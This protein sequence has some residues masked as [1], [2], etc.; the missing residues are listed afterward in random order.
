MAD[1]IT[2]KNITSVDEV[3]SV[4]NTDKVFVNDNGSFKQISVSNLMKQAPSGVTEETDPTVSE[5]AKQPTKP[6]YTADEVGAQPAL[7]IS[8]KT[9]SDT[10]YTQ[11]VKRD[12]ST[13]KLLVPA[14]GGTV[15]PE[16]IK[17]AVN[18]Y[19][20][21]NPVNPTPI[22]KTLTVENEAADAKTTGEKLNEKIDKQKGV[23]FENIGFAKVYRYGRSYFNGNIPEG[24]TAVAPLGQIIQCQPGE[25]LYCNFKLS[26]Y[27]T[28]NQRVTVINYVP[29]KNFGQFQSKSICG[30]IEQQENDIYKIPEDFTDAKA[31]FF[32]VGSMGN[33]QLGYYDR[34]SAYA[35]QNISF[36]EI[37]KSYIQEEIVPYPQ[38]EGLIVDTDKNMMLYASLF[39]A[40]SHM[41][42]A[43][44]YV[45]GD[46]I[47][48]QSSTLLN[49]TTS[50]D[51]G[52]GWYDRIGIKYIQQYECHGYEG[53]RWYSTGTLKNSA[54]ADVKKIIEAGA[55]YDY[56]VLEW[57]TNDIWSGASFG[58]A[59]DVASDADNA[60]T[61]AAIRWCIENLQ[62]NFPSTRIIVIMP[63]MRKNNS[64][65][66][67]YYTLVDTILKSYGVRRVYMAYDSGIAL[68][69]MAS[70]GIHFRY[71]DT[72]NEIKQNMIG[73]EKYSK[74][75]EAEMLKA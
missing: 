1:A 62:S 2:T 59:D 74:C 61:V 23:K 40:V 25:T 15:D 31:A 8:D 44:V 57:G 50:N 7:N 37:S 4:D 20:E 51:F 21:E 35:V 73:L 38:S 42:G 36:D 22:D 60:G 58:S 71:T 10:S 43:K 12:A 41:V 19:L 49:N 13:N 55:A 48:A 66:E 39:K 63:C 9:G 47:T 33:N 16:Q 53:N 69:M 52:K 6:S 54:V 65:Q 5:W 26:P 30:Y 45:S 27:Q 18:G 64:R 32:P 70:D 17:Q 29:D 75:L 14:S 67:Q 3:Q 46:S 68:S 56:I 11:E 72:D 24:G 28:S 34:N